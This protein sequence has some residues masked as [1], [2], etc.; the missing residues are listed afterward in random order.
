MLLKSSFCLFSNYLHH[1][2]KWIVF[3]ARCL[4]KGVALITKCLKKMWLLIEGSAMKF[5]KVVGPHKTNLNAYIWHD[6]LKDDVTVMSQKIQFTRLGCQL[7]KM[8]DLCH[9]VVIICVF[10]WFPTYN[11]K[12]HP[13]TKFGCNLAKI[14]ESR[15]LCS[16]LDSVT[17]WKRL[18]W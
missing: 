3:V 2:R 14:M 13:P 8:P 10:G 1:C 7:L 9:N 15:W 11:G 5:C 18:P 16:F 4:F 6:W 12:S 17:S